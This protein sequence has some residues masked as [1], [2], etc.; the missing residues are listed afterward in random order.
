MSVSFF[1]VESSALFHTV[2]PGLDV[3]TYCDFN[4]RHDLLF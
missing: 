4:L 2:A 1:D 3:N